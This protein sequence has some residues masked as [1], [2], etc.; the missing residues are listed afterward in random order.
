MAPSA[1]AD[2]PA[3]ALH[4]RFDEKVPIV[5]LPPDLGFEELREWMTEQIPS[6]VDVLGGRTAR[7]DLGSRGIQLLEFRRLL[8]HLRENWDIEIT[9]V[10]VAPDVVHRFAERELR[11]KLFLSEVEATDDV[12]EAAD[13]DAPNVEEEDSDEPSEG[14][15]DGLTLPNDLEESDLVEE[16]APALADATHD[17]GSRRTLSI[18]RTLR[19]GTIVRFDGDVYVFGDVNP[20][21]QVVATGNLVVLGALKGMAWAGAAGEED[22]IIL[23]HVMQPT[24]LRIGR[25]IAVLP[26]APEAPETSKL[27]R[28][29]PNKAPEPQ[30]HPELASIVEGQIVI[31]PYQGR[32]SG[33]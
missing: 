19:S 7:L 2:A 27:H 28:L 18:Q 21:A 12:A 13:E 5:Q 17:D 22:A 11:L 10:Y 15:L 14:P 32:A 31:Q 4:I 25:K 33:K 30:F 26:E 23:A 24:Q 1:V 29:W 20:G 16:D 3:S 6:H 8:H 9:G